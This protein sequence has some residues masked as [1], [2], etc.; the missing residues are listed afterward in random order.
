MEQPR[1]LHDFGAIVFHSG[2]REWA[3]LSLQDAEK[4]DATFDRNR[5]RE[6][7]T[8]EEYDQWDAHRSALHRTACSA[9]LF[10]ALAIES[11]INTI[12]VAVLRQGF[13]NEHVERQRPQAKVSMVVLAITQRLLADDDLVVQ[14]LNT[15]FRARNDIA[16]P[17]AKELDFS[18]LDTATMPKQPEP[19]GRARESVKA[20]NAFF[21]EFVAIVPQAEIWARA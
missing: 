2:F 21:K 14:A 9:I 15:V 11:F 8:E 17:K 3:L 10:S 16:H 7:M 5:R 19:A 6:D 13:F 18:S 4:M 1:S 12:G 20:M